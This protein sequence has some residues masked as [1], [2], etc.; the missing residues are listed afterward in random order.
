MGVPGDTQ[1]FIVRIWYEEAGNEN[2]AP[3]RRGSIEH[4]SSKRR[5][6]FEDPQEILRFIDGQVPPAIGS[7]P[8][9]PGALPEQARADSQ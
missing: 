2:R 5:V 7:R 6:Y 1:A 9:G 3:V 4:V 8:S